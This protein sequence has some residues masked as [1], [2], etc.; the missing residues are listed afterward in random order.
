MKFTIDC[1]RCNIL[2][3]ISRLVFCIYIEQN[4]FHWEVN[5]LDVLGLSVR[6]PSQISG[7]LFSI[8]AISPM[9]FW[10]Y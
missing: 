3:D 4:V 8:R 10:I 1:F 6:E 7:L 2:R 5:I 9:R